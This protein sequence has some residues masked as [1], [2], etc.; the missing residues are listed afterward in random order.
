LGTYRAIPSP[1]ISVQFPKK[2][3]SARAKSVDDAMD[4]DD[5]DE[6]GV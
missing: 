6:S 2:K 5:A 1:T 4:V 3:A